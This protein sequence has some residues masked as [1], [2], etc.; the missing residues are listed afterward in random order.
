MVVSRF[1]LIKKALFEMQSLG[2]C[3][4]WVS[5]YVMYS[6]AFQ[7]AHSWNFCWTQWQL[8]MLSTSQ[9]QAVKL[10]A[11][12]SRTTALNKIR[13]YW[14]S[15]IA[16]ELNSFK[17]IIRMCPCLGGGEGET[18]HKTK[19]Q[20]GFFPLFKCK[21]TDPRWKL[22]KYLFLQVNLLPLFSVF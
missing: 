11:S 14:N 6:R 13:T 1:F 2:L 5:A 4:G 22:H 21:S 20:E 8:W 7:I 9:T 12:V 10:Y 19:Q 17:Q 18:Q 15:N 16:L 3:P